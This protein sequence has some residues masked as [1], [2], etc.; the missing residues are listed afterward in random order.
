M[1]RFQGLVN[2]LVLMLALIGGST[3]MA[4]DAQRPVR[5]VAFG[6]SLT[7]GYG[8]Q[9]AEA[10]PSVLQRLLRSKGHTVEVAN[11][12][13]SGD[14]TSAGLAR[15]DWAI[16]EGTEAVI[17][18]LGAND[19]LSGRPPAQ[20]RKNLETIIGRLKG[21]GVEVLL[22][23]MRAPRNLGND[24]A[25]AFDRIFPELAEAHSLILYPFFLSGVALDPLLNL[26]D[27]MHPN[28]QGIAV[29]AE[30]ITPSVEEL[31]GRVKARRLARKG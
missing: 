26:N 23:G 6:D 11:A 5:I 14:T 16:P 31:I 25:N 30:R 2:A 10:F 9:P 22:A 17:L 4:N 24:Y 7:A 21:R 13:V 20:A 12:G 27:G 29:I 15:L 8:V 3:A 19:A 18:E 28:A 1:V